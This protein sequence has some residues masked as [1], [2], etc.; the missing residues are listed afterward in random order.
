[1]TT[2][3]DTAVAITANVLANDTDRRRRHA[4]GDAVDEPGAHGTVS[5]TTAATCTY[6]P[7]AN[8]TGAD[9][10]TY[11]ISDGNGG[12]DTATVTVTVTPV[13]DAPDAV[14]DTPDHPGGH[15]RSMTL[16]GLL[17]N[18]T[19]I[20]GD[21]LTVTGE[22]NGAHGTVSCTADRVHLHPGRELPRARTRSPTRSATATAAPTPPP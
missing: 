1:M 7:A 11:T 3:E 17:A 14:D 9:S 5:C 20:D 21:T 22:T 4:D 12:T 16:A 8:F 6:T 15:P 13:N 18:D 10:F 2:A 19:D